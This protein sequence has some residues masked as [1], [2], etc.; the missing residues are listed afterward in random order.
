GGRGAAPAQ[1]GPA[2]GAALVVPA[3]DCAPSADGSFDDN[4]SATARRSWDCLPTSPRLPRVWMFTASR[5]DWL[6]DDSSGAM[7]GAAAG[8]EGDS[9]AFGA[10]A[11]VG[12][13]PESSR[14]RTAT[15]T[16]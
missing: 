8:L 1:P 14:A 13:E 5:S 11:A 15:P 3:A 2:S 12:L 9:V 16:A 4:T 7:F 6:S 10:R